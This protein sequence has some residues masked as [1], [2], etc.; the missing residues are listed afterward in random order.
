MAPLRSKG[1]VI[2]KKI[3]RYGISVQNRLLEKHIVE[4]RL[5]N[6]QSCSCQSVSSSGKK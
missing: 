2:N 6:Y 5:N 3:P 1:R 4:E